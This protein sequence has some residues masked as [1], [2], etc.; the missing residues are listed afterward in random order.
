M[1]KKNLGTYPKDEDKFAGEYIAVVRNRII[2][3]GKKIKNVMGKAGETS[4]EP[5]LVKVP[6]LGWKQSMVLWQNIFLKVKK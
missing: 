2:A 5:L 3:H 4:N 6:A 1:K